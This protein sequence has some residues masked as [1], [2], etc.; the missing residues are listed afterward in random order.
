MIANVAALLLANALFVVAGFGIRRLLGSTHGAGSASGFALT[1]LVG[2]ASFG[3]LAQL[4][5]V[6]GLALNRVEVVALTLALG[7]AG[8]VRRRR[9]SAA[10]TASPPRR[11]R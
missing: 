10:R 11:G 3:V 7:G 6:A 9:T 2:L 5:L 8:L 1:Y 4:L